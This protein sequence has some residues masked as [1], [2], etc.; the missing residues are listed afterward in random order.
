LADR[1]LNVREIKGIRDS[2]RF[3]KEKHAIKVRGEG[4]E[5]IKDRVGEDWG[6]AQDAGFQGV[7]V[8][9]FVVLAEF[10]KFDESPREHARA[11]ALRSF[12][13]GRREAE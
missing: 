8:C 4:T 12:I 9:V 10:E 2:P 3:Q 1:L 7:R 6:A 11:G 13:N 5:F